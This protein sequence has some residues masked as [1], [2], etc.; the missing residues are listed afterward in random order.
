MLVF[1]VTRNLVIS[2]ARCLQHCGSVDNHTSYKTFSCS[3]PFSTMFPV[4]TVTHYQITRCHFSDYSTI[5][6]PNSMTN[7]KRIG[8]HQF[9]S[10]LPYVMFLAVCFNPLN[11]ELNP[12]CCLLALLGAHHFLHVNNIRVKSLTLRLLMPYI[13]GTPILDVSRSHTTTHHIR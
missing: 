1:L 5:Q 13:Y 2:I 10:C 3:W 8:I 12:I 4:Q 9:P 6:I 11:A 7:P